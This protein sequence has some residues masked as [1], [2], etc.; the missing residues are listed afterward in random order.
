[1][2]L[3]SGVAT[4]NLYFVKPHTGATA[5]LKLEKA[6]SRLAAHDCYCVGDI[7]AAESR[8]VARHENEFGSIQ[9]FG[10]VKE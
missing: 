5:E 7:D 4:L 8:D 6:C 1:M 10:A 3:E 9:D 2:L